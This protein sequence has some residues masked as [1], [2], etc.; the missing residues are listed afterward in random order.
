M[1]VLFTRSFNIA[2]L[3]ELPIL[4]VLENN[5]Y[6]QTTPVEKG[7]AGSMAGRF[8]AFGIPVWERD[9]SDVLEIGSAAGEA[10]QHTRAGAGP[11]GLIL[12]TY[13]FSAHSKGD[14]PRSP[15]ELA[16]IRIFDPLTIHGSRLSADDHE[17]AETE[18]IEVVEDAFVRADADPFP[19]LPVED[20]PSDSRL[21]MFDMP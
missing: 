8:S 20:Q 12:H 3:W 2:A 10:V 11:A 5:R 1:R 4:F 6:A 13:R 15:E 16:R 17:K 7:V 21:S 9:S 14:D 18:V 19:C